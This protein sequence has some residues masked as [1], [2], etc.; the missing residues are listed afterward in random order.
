MI[1][2]IKKMPKNAM[3]VL[4]HHTN[5]ST[6]ASVAK[7]KCFRTIFFTE[8]FLKRSRHYVGVSCFY[9]CLRLFHALQGFYERITLHNLTKFHVH[10]R[11]SGRKIWLQAINTNF[12]CNI[13]VQCTY[14]SAGVEQLLS[15]LKWNIILRH[16]PT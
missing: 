1:K 2:N 11:E 3:A 13:L 7:T 5:L 16:P 14:V 10:T 15:S 9:Q 6:R 4:G 12:N 8:S